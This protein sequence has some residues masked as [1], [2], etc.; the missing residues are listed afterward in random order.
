VD[1]PR[2]RKPRRGRWIAVAI[3]VVAVVVVSVALGRLR[4]ALPVVDA[5]TVTTA[6]VVRGPM[7]RDVRAQGRLVPLDIRWITAETSGRVERID[8]RDGAQVKADTILVEL[9]NPETVL[10]QLQ[11]EREVASAEADLL[12]LSYR[13]QADKLAQENLLWSL[14]QEQMDVERRSDA[15]QRGG[16]AVFTELDILQMKDRATSL[17]QRVHVAETELRILEEGFTSQVAAQ[18][19]QIARRREMAEFRKKQVEALRVRAGGDGVLQEMPLEVGQWVSPGTV[20][21]KVV[22]PERL[23]AELR[24]PEVQAKDVAVGQ[25]VRVDTRNG[26]VDGRVARVATAAA[27]GTVLVDVLL[28][29]ELP[30]GARPDLNVDGTIAI[31]HLED[32]LSLERPLGAQQDQPMS[33]FVVDGARG[34]A[35]RMQIEIGRMSVKAVEVKSGL[36]EGARVIVSDMSRWERSDRVALR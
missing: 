18:K 1:I 10:G 2:T 33:V 24:V 8:Y 4:Q 11:T 5:A 14:R 6:T 26:I 21:A 16:S 23:K 22:K 25:R 3:V 32:V 29:G 35:T 9:S 19:A 20:L 30:A 13:L 17:K 27:Q 12:Q 31:E 36:R 7:E 15:Y 28:D 34:E